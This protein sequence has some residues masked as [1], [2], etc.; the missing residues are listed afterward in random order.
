MPRDKKELRPQLRKF[1]KVTEASVQ[2][3]RAIIAPLVR[4]LPN[5][6]RRALRM[7]YVD[8]ASVEYICS[9]CG[10]APEQ[11]WELRANLRARHAELRELSRI[12]PGRSTSKGSRRSGPRHK[13]AVNA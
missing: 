9:E 13:P 4:D 2:N 12:P 10:L 3:S 8:N 11:F 5:N 7:W 6:V 1:G